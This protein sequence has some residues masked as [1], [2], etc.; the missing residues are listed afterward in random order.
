[1]YT[2]KY[3]FGR[4]IVQLRWSLALSETSHDI[5]R[6]AEL[7]FYLNKAPR[8]IQ[9]HSIKCY[10]FFIS[11]E[12]RHCAKDVIEYGTI[13]VNL[14]IDSYGGCYRIFSSVN[15]WS[16]AFLPNLKPH[17]QCAISDWLQLFTQYARKNLTSDMPIPLPFPRRL[18][19]RWACFAP[20]KFYK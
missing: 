5:K 13:K 18:Q 2:P 10:L 4:N 12:V 15:M 16:M 3:L 17:C 1:M 7:F 14:I 6:F 9:Q 11:T 19:N 8:V 20:V